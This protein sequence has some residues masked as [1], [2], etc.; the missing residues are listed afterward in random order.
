MS[1]TIPKQ[2]TEA[3]PTLEEITAAARVLSKLHPGLLPL[4]I[5]LETTRLT[6]SSIVEVVPLRK[7][8]DSVEVLL[9]KRDS[10]DP[11][12]PGMLHTP[13]T[14]VRPTDEEG[15]YASAFERILG[16]ELASVKLTGEPQ[17]VD[18]VLHKVKRG[19]EDAKIFFVEVRGEPTTGAFYNVQAL[20]ENVVD[21]QIDFIHMAAQKFAEGH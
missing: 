4:P 21:T 2:K 7:R 15:S 14:V 1:E 3:E 11:N 19:M 5:F 16:G 6:V 12:W 10:D 13:G 9:T 18:S 17:Y 20:P 8:G